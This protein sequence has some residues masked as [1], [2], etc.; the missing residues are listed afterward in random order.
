MDFESDFL[1]Y[2][3]IQDSVTMYINMSIQCKTECH[4]KCQ[5]QMKIVFQ[6]TLSFWIICYVCWFWIENGPK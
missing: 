5:P 3:V 6:T 4:I 1:K 2:Y